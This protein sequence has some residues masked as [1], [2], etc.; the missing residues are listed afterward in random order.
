MDNGVP[1]TSTNTHSSLGMWTHLHQ[2]IGNQCFICSL[3]IFLLLHYSSVSQFEVQ[4]P[5]GENEVT[6]F[7]LTLVNFILLHWVKGSEWVLVG[8]GRGKWGCGS[9]IIHIINPI[10][11]FSKLKFSSAEYMTVNENLEL[12][13]KI[14][15]SNI[16]L[17]F[18]T[19]SFTFVVVTYSNHC[20]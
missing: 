3:A 18:S 9:Y 1:V 15:V 20:Y 10:D 11:V 12:M 14:C 4:I 16:S 2:D 5:T 8:N 17:C 6:V 19:E 13:C 7:S